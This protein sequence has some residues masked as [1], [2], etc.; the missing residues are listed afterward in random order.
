MTQNSAQNPE[1]QTAC[2]S[3]GQQTSSDGA[4]AQSEAQAAKAVSQPAAPAPEP[5]GPEKSGPESSAAA[6]SSTGASRPVTIAAKGFRGVFGNIGK[7]GKTASS[8]NPAG[9]TAQSAAQPTAPSNVQ[10]SG[11][12]FADNIFELLVLLAPWPCCSSC[13]PR[14]GLPSWATAFTA[15]ARPQA[16]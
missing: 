14:H 6:G 1:G 12:G 8:A 16:S 3:G 7:S 13:W 15:P 11:P 9:Q 2:Q 5:S 4:H 10:P